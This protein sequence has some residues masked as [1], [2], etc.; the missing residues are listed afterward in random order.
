MLNRRFSD[1]L[2][3][4]SSLLGKSAHPRA[5]NLSNLSN[6]IY[7]KQ[8]YSEMSIF[9]RLKKEAVKFRFSCFL[10]MNFFIGARG[11]GG[12]QGKAAASQFSQKY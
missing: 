2:S 6:T 1:P 3:I 4:G 10:K 12:G 8:K 5:R 7:I 9:K 11:G